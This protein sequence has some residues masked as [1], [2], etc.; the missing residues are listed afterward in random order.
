MRIGLL[1][2]IVVAVACGRPAAGVAPLASPTPTPVPWIA[3]A[4]HPTPFPIPTSTPRPTGVRGCASSDLVG[5]FDGGQ[6]AGGS[7]T[8]GFVIGNRSDTPC[9]VDGPIRAAYVDAHGG[10]IVAT[11]IQSTSLTA[12]WVVLG[13]LTEPVAGSAHREGQAFIGLA[14]YGD[15]GSAIG[16]AAVALTFTEPTNQVVIPMAAARVGGRCDVPEQRLQLG[17]FFALGPAATPLPP[18]TPA[19]RLLSFAIEAPPTAMAGAALDYVVRI[20]NVSAQPYT[21]E[22]GCPLYLEWLGG[23]E[24]TP[25]IRPSAVSKQEVPFP[26][27]AGGVKELH[28]LNCGPAG[29]IPSGADVGFEMHINVPADARGPDMLR[30]EIIGEVPLGSASAAILLVN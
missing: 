15:C 18:Q 20:R 5:V 26:V 3:D 28:S 21:W 30:W 1:L 14:T 19:P 16:V 11:N 29:V 10:E 27:Y 12:G 23:H 6:G 4:A 24:I 2:A 25:T 8:R 9:I 7:I 22:G 17:I 13:A